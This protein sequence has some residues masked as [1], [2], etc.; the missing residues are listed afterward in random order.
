MAKKKK[1]QKGLL[2][3]VRD[4]AFPFLAASR[5][6]RAL[7]AFLAFGA[8]ASWAA[9]GGGALG[10][11][12]RGAGSREVGSRSLRSSQ[13]LGFP[14]R[15]WGPGD[16]VVALGRAVAGSLDPG[17]PHPHCVF[18]VSYLHRFPVSPKADVSVRL[19]KF[20]ERSTWVKRRRFLGSCGTDW[21]PGNRGRRCS[22]GV[23]LL[24]FN[25]PHSLTSRLLSE[26]GK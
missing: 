4:G 24:G 13:E 7:L 11:G 16:R 8:S 18:K 25:G 5:W 17:C 12:E 1:V 21:R 9:A 23:T 26:I 19:C 3:V 15:G 14:A 2:C 6:L 22:P 20:L 10:W